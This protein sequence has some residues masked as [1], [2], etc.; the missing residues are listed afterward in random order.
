MYNNEIKVENG[1]FSII[2]ISEIDSE[3]NLDEFKN[4]LIK[5]NYKPN[6]PMSDDEI[7][8]AVEPYKPILLDEIQFIINSF[9]EV[10]D[11]Y[12]FDN[13]FYYYSYDTI[14]T[15]QKLLNIGLSLSVGVTKK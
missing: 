13:N 3:I 5:I 8:Q 15:S 7:S 2:S 14:Q 11:N 6:Q 4:D 12:N 10:F 9:P 1:V